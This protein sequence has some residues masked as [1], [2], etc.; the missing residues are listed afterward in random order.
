MSVDHADR[1]Y[2]EWKKSKMVELGIATETSKIQVVTRERLDPKKKTRVQTTSY[3]FESRSLY[4]EWHRPFYVLKQEPDPTLNPNKGTRNK[5]RKQFPC[6][7]VFWFNHPLALAVFYMDDGGVQS[8]Q[9]YFATGEV[10][11]RE[12]K[13]MQYALKRNFDLETSTR[14]AKDVP[15]GL[16]VR[17]KDCGKF[18]KLVEPYVN[19][20]PTMRYKLN[21]T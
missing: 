21:I 11:A 5:R 2:V 20:V 4:E 13:F 18:V 1:I 6:E 16:L 12:V 15:V 9:A 14:Y 8:N 17:R 10:S 7:L 3:R 19:L